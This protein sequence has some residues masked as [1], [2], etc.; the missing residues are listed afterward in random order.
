MTYAERRRY[1]FQQVK[2]QLTAH[3]I[4]PVISP[5]LTV[6]MGILMALPVQRL[7][8]ECGHQLPSLA[9]SAEKVMKV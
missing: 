2:N 6:M 3:L 7:W 8:V 5:P 9:L 4:Y 1:C